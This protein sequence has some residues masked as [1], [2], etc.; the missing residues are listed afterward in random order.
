MDKDIDYNEMT[1]RIFL[2]KIRSLEDENNELIK[3]F[4]D[5]IESKNKYID[6]LIEENKKLE[7][8]LN[9]W[10]EKYTKDM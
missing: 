5:I 9:D 4:K 2:D 6:E 3:K 1:N 8:Q 10:K 7:I